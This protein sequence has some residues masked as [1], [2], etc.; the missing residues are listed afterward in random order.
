M[1]DGLLEHYRKEADNSYS[2]EISI[3]NLDD[4][5]DRFDPSPLHERDVNSKLVE[6]IAKQIVVFPEDVKVKLLLHVPKRFEKRKGF[7]DIVRKALKHHFEYEFLDNHQ[8]MKRRIRKAS[9][10]FLTASIIF[11]FLLFVYLLLKTPA[12]SSFILN[13]ISEGIFIG[14]WVSIWH[15]IHILFYEWV[16]LHEEKK[17]F[18]RLMNVEVQFKYV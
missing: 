10:T 9:K 18:Q 15:P 7:E 16:P 6:S 17:K 12:E 11:V 3:S 4:L 13:L 5:F 2:I 8:H 14:A 1:E